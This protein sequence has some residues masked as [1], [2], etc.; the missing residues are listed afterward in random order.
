MYNIPGSNNLEF[1]L[2]INPIPG[3]PGPRGLNW[4]GPWNALTMYAVD[5]AVSYQG[6]S[7]VSIRAGSN[8]LPSPGGTSYWQ[9][10]AD[11]GIP[12]L[13]W[14]GQWDV[15][16]NYA[17]NDGVYWDGSSYIAL[18]AGIG[19]QPVGGSAD[20]YWSL[21]AK[22]GN[23]G[24]DAEGGGEGGSLQYSSPYSGKNNT[25]LSQ[26]IKDMDAYRQDP[27]IHYW[28][29]QI[30]A[31]LQ[32]PNGTYQYFIDIRFVN[33][34]GT[35]IG[36][37]IFLQYSANLAQRYAGFAYLNLKHPTNQTAWGHMTI[38]F[39]V[40][41]PGGVYQNANY[42][43]GALFGIT[44]PGSSDSSGSGTGGADALIPKIGGQ[45]AEEDLLL[46]GSEKFVIFNDEETGV[47][48][49]VAVDLKSSFMVINASA[50]QNFNIT[51]ENGDKPINGQTTQVVA[52]GKWI[53]VMADGPDAI[54]AYGEFTPLNL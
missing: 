38:D 22:K 8:Q 20:A 15:A 1:P 10:L 34:G 23:D 45:T 46:D 39:S 42:G 44:V 19:H 13:N 36:A 28:V 16:T 33:P 54:A 47:T 50:T 6:R 43:E 26:A 14:K 11:E 17:I 9:L 41:S 25:I 53:A 7:Y 32:Q 35:P 3:P 18:Q 24:K 31:G 5:D 40:L 12:G 49:K 29:K 2:T 51:S 37:D 30:I 21:L 52:P 48:V 4:M 27:N